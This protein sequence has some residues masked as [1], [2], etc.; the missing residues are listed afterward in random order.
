[1]KYYFDISDACGTIIPITTK[2]KDR[3]ELVKSIKIYRDIGFCI[4]KKIKK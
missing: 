2:C 1:M 4:W 3:Y